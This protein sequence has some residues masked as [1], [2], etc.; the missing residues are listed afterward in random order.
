[1]FSNSIMQYYSYSSCHETSAAI[2]AYSSG[3]SDA[4]GLYLLYRPSMLYV[5]I[6]G[7]RKRTPDQVSYW[8]VE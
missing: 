5:I 4:G 7:Y 2:E 1:M 6:L 8:N 3:T